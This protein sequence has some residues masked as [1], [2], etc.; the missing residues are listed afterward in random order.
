MTNE[1]DI[2]PD[3]D[4]KYRTVTWQSSDNRFI[5]F[6]SDFPCLINATH[7]CL[8]N[9]GSGRYTRY[10]WN[11]GMFIIWNHIAYRRR[12]SWITCSAKTHIWTY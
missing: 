7:N 11:N 2:N 9:S 12:R 8:L 1:E 5:Y 4:V 6:V 3:V 10:M